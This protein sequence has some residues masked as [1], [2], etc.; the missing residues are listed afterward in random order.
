[1]T[2]PTPSSPTV[3]TTAAT[4]RPWVVWLISRRNMNMLTSSRMIATETEKSGMKSGLSTGSIV[5]RTSNA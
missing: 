3:L 4:L 1:M 2:A 5:R